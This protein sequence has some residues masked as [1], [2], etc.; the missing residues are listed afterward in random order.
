MVVSPLDVRIISLG[1]GTNV[2]E[3]STVALC[4]Y[5]ILNDTSLVLFG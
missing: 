1:G 3:G 2:A 4:V 5:V